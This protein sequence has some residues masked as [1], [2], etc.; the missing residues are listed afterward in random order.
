MIQYKCERHL[1]SER[2]QVGEV[3]GV[4]FLYPVV[5]VLICKCK[6]QHS[7]F[8][9]VGLVDT[10]EGLYEYDLYTKV[11]RLHGCVLPGGSLSIVFIA[12]DYSPDPLQLV[13]AL[14]LWYFIVLTGNRVL[15]V[16]DLLI[17]EVGGSNQQVI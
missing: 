2:C 6:S 8:L 17:K 1:R 16:I 15:Y 7:L 13:C 10:G 9:Q 3:D 11:A 14:N 12:N 4:V 5:V